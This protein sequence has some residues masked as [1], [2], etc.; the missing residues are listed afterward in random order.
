MMIQFD[1]HFL[2]QRSDYFNSEFPRCYSIINIFIH[3]KTTTKKTDFF[4][5]LTQLITFQKYHLHLSENE[6][7]V[8]T[9]SNSELQQQVHRTVAQKTVTQQERRLQCK[10]I[11]PALDNWQNFIYIVL[12][13]CS[14]CT[15]QLLR[16]MRNSAI[17]TKSNKSQG[18][19]SS[20]VHSM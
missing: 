17:R 13:Y 8:V 11:S 9:Q 20:T 5:L 18:H 12:S 19:E 7:L 15:E 6:V 2:T 3:K 14:K 10:Y 1:I 16:K 4:L